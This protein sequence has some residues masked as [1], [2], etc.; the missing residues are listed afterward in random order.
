[1]KKVVCE[2]CGSSNVVKKGEYFVCQ[3]CGMQ[4]DLESARAMMVEVTGQVDVSGSTVKVDNSSL[5]EKYLAN[6]R[7]AKEKQDY[8]EMEKYYNMV[9]ANDPESIEALFY[10][11][12]AKVKQTLVDSNLFK[13]QAEF[14]IFQKSISIIDDNFKVEK[15]EENIKLIQDIS[16]DLV[17]LYYGGYVYNQKKNGYGIVISSD[18]RETEV[19]FFYVAGEFVS[20]LQNIYKSLSAEHAKEKIAL[21]KLIIWHLNYQKDSGLCTRESKNNIRENRIPALHKLWNELDPSHPI[22]EVEKDK[23]NGWNDGKTMAK[24]ALICSCIPIPLFSLIGLIYALMGLSKVK[25][26][27]KSFVPYK[28]KFI[29]SII[30]AIVAFIVFIGFVSLASY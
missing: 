17:S 21:I 4:Y 8:A 2:M 26:G 9:E 6:A 13:R 12:Y 29:I 18:K 24:A 3:D 23:A 1:M 10:S 27:E 5:V 19:L 14:K 7:R 28:K 15:L 11:A 25:Q 16:N 22:P 30:C 20:T